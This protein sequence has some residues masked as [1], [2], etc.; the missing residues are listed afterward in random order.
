MRRGTIGATIDDY[1]EQCTRQSGLRPS[2]EVQRRV[3]DDFF[4]YLLSRGFRPNDTTGKLTGELIRDWAACIAD[5]PL[6][7]GERFPASQ[8]WEPIPLV[9]EA[10][11]SVAIDKNSHMVQRHWCG[12][13][14]PM[15]VDLFRTHDST[16]LY[17]NAAPRLALGLR[18]QQDLG[19]T[20][21]Q[22]VVMYPAEAMGLS[23]A[24]SDMAK[25]RPAQ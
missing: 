15:F 13:G 8:D 24:L 10:H 7:R 6:E 5:R 12:P 17:R 4:Q 25:W 16:G 1:L 18:H 22:V 14:D 20:A 21:G 9:V 11:E 23:R 19:L 2:I 3:L